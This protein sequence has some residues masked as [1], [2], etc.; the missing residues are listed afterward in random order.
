MEVDWVAPQCWTPWRHSWTI[1]SSRTTV[2]RCRRPNCPVYE[3][4][5]L[6]I[7]SAL[8]MR[9]KVLLLDEPA[10]GLTRP[11]IAKL[12]A[13][14]RKINGAGVTI[15]LIEHVLS[16]LMSVS[17]RLIVLNQG[18]L[19]AEGDPRTVFGDPRRDRGLSWWRRRM[20]RLLD[21]ESLTAGYGSVTVLRG[22]SLHMN[23]GENIGLFGPNGHG[24][25]HADARVVGA[26]ARNFRG[27]PSLRTGHLACAAL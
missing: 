22:L 3:R 15:L 13:L 1:P 26:D 25:T 23:A 17:E 6:L 7:A 19:L 4:K 2:Q 10:S 8:V 11:E 24:K 16:L 20:S 5:Q 27:L 21:V 9:P 12:D 18:K 14:L